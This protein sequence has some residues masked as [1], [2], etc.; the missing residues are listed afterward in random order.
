VDKPNPLAALIALDPDF[1]RYI[2]PNRLKLLMDAREYVGTARERAGLLAKQIRE[3][4][5]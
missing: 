5:A 4:V 1:L 2:Q 3:Q